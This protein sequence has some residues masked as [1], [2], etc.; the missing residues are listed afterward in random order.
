MILRV[1]NSA[2]IPLS[3]EGATAVLVLRRVGWKGGRSSI[4]QDWPGRKPSESFAVLK[5]FFTQ[6]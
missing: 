6:L 4:T 1:G 5:S 2:E 3:L